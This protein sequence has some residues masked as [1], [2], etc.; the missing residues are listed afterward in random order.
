MAGQDR[1]SA[2]DLKSDDLK[3]DDLK[4]GL[5]SQL[6]DE[7]KSFSFFQAMRLLHTAG[8]SG[9]SG[10]KSQCNGV[11]IR[12]HLSLGFPSA[13]IETI[14]K[15]NNNF[16]TITAAFL[17]LYGTSSPLPTFYTEDLMDEE[18]NDSSVA[19]DFV[20]IFNQRLF[21]L[22]YDGWLKYRQYL[23]VVEGENADYLDRLY[24]LVGLGEEILRKK[25]KDSYGL[26]RYAG[27]FTQSPRSALGLKTLLH[28]ALGR[29]PVTIIP[30]MK[31]KA[32]IPDDQRLCLGVSGNCL[33][34]ESI[35]GHEI[36]DRM[37]KF[38]IS[39]GPLIEK[40]YRDFFPGKSK[41]EKLVSLTQSFLETPLEYDIE[42]ILAQSQINTVCL[43]G[44][45]WSQLGL[46]TW[47]F[48][49]MEV[50]DI[51]EVRSVFRPEPI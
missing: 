29:A 36:D 9:T 24:C 49:D 26:I 1:G 50:S 3:S 27:L 6:L 48:S 21:E 35:L 22:L 37:G 32:V 17:G 14:E 46:D 44:D 15:D 19:R 39:I 33:G 30:C 13:D 47:V 38:R 40:D 28:D 11:K 2:S 20:D 43:G 42:L 34:S 4:S 18:A 41:Y 16:F 12:P 25:K 7:G 45:K 51:E 10:D 23:Q 31:R 8:R 5:I